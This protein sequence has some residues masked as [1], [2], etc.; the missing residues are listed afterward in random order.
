[1]VPISEMAAESGHNHAHSHAGH[2]H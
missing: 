2:S 1:V